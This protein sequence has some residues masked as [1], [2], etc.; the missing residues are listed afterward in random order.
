MNWKMVG[1]TADESTRVEDWSEWRIH[2]DEPRGILDDIYN[3]LRSRGLN[4]GV[5]KL[6]P[7]K[8]MV[9]GIIL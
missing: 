7:G 6:G 1:S 8:Y 3:D 4:Q 9:K 5:T 2:S